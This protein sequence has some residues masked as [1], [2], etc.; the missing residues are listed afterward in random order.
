MII[1]DYWQCSGGISRE[2]AREI[3][4][5]YGFQFEV[6]RISRFENARNAVVIANDD[7][8]EG[9]VNR[10][11]LAEEIQHGLDRPAREASKAIQRGLSNERFH[12]EVFRRMLNSNSEG[13]FQFLTEGDVAA[14]RVL[15]EGWER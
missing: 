8:R 12:A 6:G 5:E 2:E 1:D 3:T 11:E 10:I 7:M 9:L 13:R 14:I 4:Q 15:I